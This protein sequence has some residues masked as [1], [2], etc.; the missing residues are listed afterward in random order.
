MEAG[1]RDNLLAAKVSTLLDSR[2]DLHPD[3][4]IRQVFWKQA[5][6]YRVAI[7]VDDVHGNANGRRRL[8]KGYYK[9]VSGNVSRRRAETLHLDDLR[10]WMDRIATM[11]LQAAERIADTDV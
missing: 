1:K 11:A 7:T 8:F 10:S 9:T 4:A 6:A 5:R 2:P 3:Q